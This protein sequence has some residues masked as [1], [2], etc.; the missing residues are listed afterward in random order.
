MFKTEKEKLSKT[1]KPIGQLEN[2]IMYNNCKCFLL[3]SGILPPKKT[4]KQKNPKNY[5]FI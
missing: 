5:Q 4:Q 1:T 3:L 2:F